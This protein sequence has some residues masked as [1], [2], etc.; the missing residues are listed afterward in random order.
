[1]IVCKTTAIAGTQ[2][3]V[4]SSWFVLDGDDDLTLQILGTLINSATDKA[5]PVDADMVGLTDSAAGNIT[6]K[7]S[8]L[9]IKATLKTY[10]D[11]LYAAAGSYLTASSTS[12][13]TNK[14]IDAD[15]TGNSITNLR[16]ADLAA[17]VIDTDLSSVSSSDDTIPSAKATK[18][19][20][21]AKEA[22]ANKDATGGYA[23]L[24]LFKINF[25]NAANTF[26]NF[27]TNATT[28]A[29]TYTFPDKDGTVAMTSDIT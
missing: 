21:D 19:A 7:L 4:G 2:A 29:R 9:N 24:T 23:G 8:W 26:T 10:F 28:A 16:V 14:T 5:T 25:K 15:G 1:M 17:G 13:L 22:T 11:T 27:L 6:K 12:T 3:A 20:L 18:T